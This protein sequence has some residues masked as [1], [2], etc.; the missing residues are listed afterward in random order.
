MRTRGQLIGFAN[1]IWEGYSHAWIQDLMVASDATPQG[2][3]SRSVEEIRSESI[4]AGCEWLHVNFEEALTIFYV[5]AG[6]S[7]AS[8]AGLLYLR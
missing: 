1:V 8:S 5:G 4:K 3:R 7:R 2:V 6:G